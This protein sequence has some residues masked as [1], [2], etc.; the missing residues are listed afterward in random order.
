MR[1]RT[2]ELPNQ[3]F[4][5]S[6]TVVIIGIATLGSYWVLTESNDD[7]TK[8]GVI[9]TW[10]LLLKGAWDFWFGSSSG[11]KMRQKKDQDN[12]DNGNSDIQ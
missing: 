5:Q 6:L 12:V 4:L 9:A 7:L 11:G 2:D 1:K 3:L 10:T 8:G